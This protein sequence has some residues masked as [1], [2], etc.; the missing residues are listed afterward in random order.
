MTPRRSIARH[1]LSV[2]SDRWTGHSAVCLVPDTGLGVWWCVIYAPYL[3]LELQLGKMTRLSRCPQPRWY[4]A[5]LYGLLVPA[6]S[7]ARLF[8]LGKLKKKKKKGRPEKREKEVNNGKGKKKV[9]PKQN[10]NSK[11]SLRAPFYT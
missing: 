2:A 4:V 7:A 11:I 8:Q 10:R 1:E 5:C 9:K 3:N 6:G